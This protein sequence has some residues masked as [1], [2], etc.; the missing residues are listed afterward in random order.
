MDRSLSRAGTRCPWLPRLLRR[1]GTSAM[2]ERRERSVQSAENGRGVALT[3]PNL[4]AARRAPEHVDSVHTQ[5]PRRA[6]RK[7]SN[8]RRINVTPWQS[9]PVGPTVGIKVLS[10]RLLYMRVLSEN[11]RIVK[12]FHILSLSFLFLFLSYRIQFENIFKFEIIIKWP[13]KP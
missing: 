6:R 10:C 3:R 2:M 11:A 5:M 8:L 4:F 1:Y 13:L 12:P 9:P 7:T